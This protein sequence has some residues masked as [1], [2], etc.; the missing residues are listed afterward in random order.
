MNNG[1]ANVSFILQANPAAIHK[2]EGVYRTK[3]S[4]IPDKDKY[5]K[6]VNSFADWNFDDSQIGESQDVLKSVGNKTLNISKF[7]TMLA[8]LN[9]ELNT[10]GFHDMYVYFEVK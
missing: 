6:A 1:T 10:P 4:L 8:N 3:I 5:T 2:K 7:I 9:Y